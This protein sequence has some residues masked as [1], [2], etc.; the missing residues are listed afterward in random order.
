MSPHSRAPLCIDNPLIT[1]FFGAADRDQGRSAA[2]LQVA[3]CQMAAG[4]YIYIYIYIYNIYIY[5]YTQS[6]ASQASYGVAMTRRLLKI[7]GLF[8]KKSSV[9]ETI[10]SAK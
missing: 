5:K 4:I 2:Y 9:K 1:I 10:F 3:T 6:E 8:C 7:T